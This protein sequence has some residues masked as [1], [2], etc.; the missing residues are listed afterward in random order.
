MLGIANYAMKGPMQAIIAVVVFSALS[1]FLA[2]FC[3]LVGVFISLVPLLFSEP[4]I[5]Y[6][7]GP[8]NII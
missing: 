1:V 7:S 6:E 3:I 2:P 8:F 5:L 4:Y